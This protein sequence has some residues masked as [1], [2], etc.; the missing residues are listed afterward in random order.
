ML[1]GWQKYLKSL[2]FKSLKLESFKKL[3]FFAVKM[4]LHF[5]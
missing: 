3:W 5:S 2:E 4:L 1:N